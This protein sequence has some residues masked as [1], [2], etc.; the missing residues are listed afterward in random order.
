MDKDIER[1]ILKKIIEVDKIAE[2]LEKIEDKKNEV[3]EKE[4]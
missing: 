3:K 2:N 4:V 1:A